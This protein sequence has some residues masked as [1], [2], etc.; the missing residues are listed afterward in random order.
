MFHFENQKSFYRYR[1]QGRKGNVRAP[2][3]L[4]LLDIGEQQNLLRR[5]FAINNEKVQNNENKNED[6]LHGL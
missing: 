5:K 1:H 4:R 2:Y 3:F 6:K